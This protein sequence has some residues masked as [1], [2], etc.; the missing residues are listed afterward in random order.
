[1]SRDILAP[2]NTGRPLGAPNQGVQRFNNQISQGDI[3][4]ASSGKQVSSLQ[5]VDFTPANR[6][7]EQM[8]TIANVGE[9][10][11]NATLKVQRASEIAKK[12]SRDAYLAN[13]EVDDIVQTNRIYNENAAQGNDPEVL[14]TKL[15]EYREGKRAA[16]PEEIQPYYAQSFDKRAATLT[17]KS[18]DAF[19]QKAQSDAKTGLES[20]QK[21]IADDI[22]TNPA[23]KTEIEMQ[24]YEDKITKLRATVQ[25]RVDHGFITPEEAQLEE[26]AFQ[27]DIVVAGYKA[28]MQNMSPNMRA[29]AIFNVQQGRGLPDAFNVND[30][31]D[32]VKQ[33]N[34]Y[35]NTAEATQKAAF[36][37][38]NAA[39]ALKKSRN[40]ADLEIRVS[41]GEATYEEVQAAESKQQIT[42]DKKASLFKALD[43]NTKEKISE[44]DALQKV[45]RTLDGKDTID[46]K[47]SKDMKAVDLAY[48]KAVTPQLEALQGDPAAQKT[49]VTNFVQ[50]TGVV[51]GPLQS[52]IR[53]VFRGSNVEDK[54]M[55]ADLVGRI[56][57]TKPQAI[58]D[59][60][61]KDVT[62]AIMIDQLVKAGTPN[63]EAV[64]KVEDITNNITPGRIEMLKAEYQ[65][66]KKARG[67]D[68]TSRST[69]VLDEVTDLFDEGVLS[70]DASLPDRQ[71]GV[72]IAAVS[73]YDKLYETWYLNTN[74]D[75]DLAKKQA[76]R[77]FK[78]S[79][80]TTAINGQAKQLTKYPVEKAYPMLET[81]DLKTSLMSDLKILPEYKDISEDKVF[82]QYDSRTAREWGKQPSYRVLVMNKDGVIE[83]VADT[84]KSRWAPAYKDLVNDKRVN[85]EMDARLLRERTINSSTTKQKQKDAAARQNV[86]R[87]GKEIIKEF[88]NLGD[89]IFSVFISEA[90]AAEPTP[91]DLQQ[92]GSKENLTTSQLR[93]TMESQNKQM[94][95]SYNKAELVALPSILKDRYYRS[96]PPNREVTVANYRQYD[97]LSE[98]EV[99]NILIAQAQENPG[100]I[101]PKDIEEQ[102]AK[103]VARYY[104]REGS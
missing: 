81:K 56:Q 90:G 97:D 60:D 3:K 39:A 68:S 17:V 75:A 58:D 28:Q 1:M 53:G 19:F 14:A 93:Q 24:A 41:R 66:L 22:F 8:S 32:I 16:M 38:E 55:Y 76:D 33:L 64:K 82:L 27:K 31:E 96:P 99:R 101:T 13:V 62:Q 63:E 20:A 42:P 102:P 91:M 98:D 74:G 89:K 36:A 37:E 104:Q 103:I 2:Q 18:Q 92:F 44:S 51:P 78:S 7:I 9:G 15:G 94:P 79:W 48:T 86:K 46:P 70:R 88:K 30:K 67:V 71:L 52:K 11:L 21:I 40:I 23:P 25:A 80:G 83:P 95:G 72:H 35:S 61:D 69:K 85:A 100:S 84:S 6:Y 50:A 87:A 65:E 34:A 45:A 77:A 47:D 54:V 4:Q 57:E 43:A 5:P 12:S 49:L 29:K 26:R 59:F 10:I 73:D